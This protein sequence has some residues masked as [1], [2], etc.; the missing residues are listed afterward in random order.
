MFG[1]KSNELNQTKI[2]PTYPRRIYSFMEY[3]VMSYDPRKESIEAYKRMIKYF[4]QQIAKLQREIFSELCCFEKV[5]KN[6][7]YLRVVNKPRITK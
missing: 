5:D 2:V 7:I 6:R 1:E 4:E 3:S